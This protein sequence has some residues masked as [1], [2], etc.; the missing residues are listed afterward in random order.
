MFVSMIELT[1]EIAWR[2]SVAATDGCPVVVGSVQPDGQP[3]LAHYGSVQVFD[4]QRL[5]LWVRDPAADLLARIRLNPRVTAL[6]RHPADRVAWHF[7]GVAARNDDHDVRDQVYAGC[8][9]SDRARDPDQGGVAVIIEVVRVRG[10][11]TDVRRES[12]TVPS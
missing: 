7:E 10:K 11:G 1:P 9:A 2:L 8:S 12:A 5:A 3:R 4:E 6:Y